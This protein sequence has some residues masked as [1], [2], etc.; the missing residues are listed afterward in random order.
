MANRNAERRA[1]IPWLTE[2]L[3]AA[4]R[5]EERADSTRLPRRLKVST[6]WRSPALVD[7]R[8]NQR[9]RRPPQLRT[10]RP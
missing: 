3:T 8:T 9:S 6:A 1:E 10:E 2:G 5:G 7:I 4:A